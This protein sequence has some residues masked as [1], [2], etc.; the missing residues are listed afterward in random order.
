MT[1]MFRPGS[2]YAR[3][4]A[5]L[6]P[7]AYGVSEWCAVDELKSLG[8]SFG[9]GAGIIRAD[10]GFCKKYIVGKERGDSSSNAITSIRT[11]GFA[12]QTPDALRAATIPI[13]VRA[14]FKYSTCPVLGTSASEI[15]HKE[16]RKQD[17]TNDKN[18]FQPFT[19]HANTAKRTHCAACKATGKRF[20]A[21]TLGFTVAYT[22]GGS[23]YKASEG[24]RGCYWYDVKAFH[25]ELVIKTIKKT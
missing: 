3:L 24:C 18:A 19:K 4:E 14:E 2:S 22:F 6:K 17:S 16:G 12:A 23:R 20:D 1:I 8:F 5:H 10:G 25:S 9:N 15:D 13:G 7:D 11:E 21:R